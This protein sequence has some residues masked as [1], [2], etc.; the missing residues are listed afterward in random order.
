[1][2]RRKRQTNEEKEELEG[3]TKEKEKQGNVKEERQ[4]KGMRK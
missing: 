2:N 4:V 3:E 1:M